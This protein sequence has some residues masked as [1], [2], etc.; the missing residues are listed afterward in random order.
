[1]GRLTRAVAAIL[2]SGYLATGAWAILA[3]TNWVH[4]YPGFGRHW[5]DAADAGSPH[6]IADTAAGFLAVGVALLTAAVLGRRPAMQVGGLALLAHALPHFVHHLS[7][8]DP[9]LPTIDVVVGVWGIAIQAAVGL[10]LFAA[11]AR[12][13]REAT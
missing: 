1:M 3:P 4:S 2:G 9:H 6:L 11:A 5:L 13:E 12:P 8:P 7:H 10:A